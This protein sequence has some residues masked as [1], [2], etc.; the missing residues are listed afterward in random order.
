[1]Q[2]KGR[3]CNEGEVIVEHEERPHKP[4]PVKEYWT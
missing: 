4:E 3:P 1:M 2:N